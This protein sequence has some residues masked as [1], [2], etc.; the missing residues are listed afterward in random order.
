MNYR[1]HEENLLDLGNEWSVTGK[2]RIYF[3]NL[4]RFINLKVNTFKS[5]NVS[6]ATLDGRKI[7]NSSATKILRILSGVKCWYDFSDGKLH[8]RGSD[9][10]RDEVIAGIRVKIEGK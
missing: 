7:S 2:R 3:N 5:H 4:T 1:Q 10:W 8:W 6:S 9:E